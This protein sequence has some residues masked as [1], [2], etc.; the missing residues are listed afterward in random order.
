MNV[1]DEHE[2]NVAQPRVTAGSRR[3]LM[4][5]AGG[6]VLGARGLFLPDWLEEAEARKGANGGSLGGRRG[7]D[8]RGRQKRKRRDRGENQDKQ[9]DRDKPR[10]ENPFLNREVAVFVHNY[11]KDPVKVTGW[12]S[13][14]WPHEDTYFI[15]PGWETTI[16]GRAADGSHSVKQFM[17]SGFDMAVVIGTDRVV[18]CQNTYGWPPASIRTGGWNS[19]GGFGGTILTEASMGVHQSISSDGIKITRVDDLDKYILFSV[20]LT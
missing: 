10:G 14:S 7:K 1:A 18:R 9:Q 11:R 20:D 5:A 12:Q 3:H 6:L 13:H 15:S 4:R 16:P 17:S 8:R 2:E 19:D